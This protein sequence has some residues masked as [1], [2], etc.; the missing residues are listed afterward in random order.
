MSLQG[1]LRTV[2][3]APVALNEA[4][5]GEGMEATATRGLPRP[6]TG[7]QAREILENIAARSQQ[8]GTRFM[9]SGDRATLLL[10]RK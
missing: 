5:H 8:F 3:F 6:A 4:G 10:G 9:I 2:T 1:Q 7:V